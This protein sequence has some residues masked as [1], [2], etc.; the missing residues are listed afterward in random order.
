MPTVRT[1]TDVGAVIRAARVER[2]WT[3]AELASRADVSRRWVSAT[4]SGDAQ[5]TELARVLRVL[6]ALGVSL[7]ATASGDVASA[8]APRFDLAAHLATF[9]VVH[10]VGDR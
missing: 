3:Q 6:A 1:V 8:A 4:E 2:G 10:P 9:D 7:I 5:R